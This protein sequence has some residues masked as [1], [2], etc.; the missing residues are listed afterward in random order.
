MESE[1]CA[2]KKACIDQMFVIL[3]FETAFFKKFDWEVDYVGNPVLDAVK[4]HPVD[5]I[6][7]TKRY[8]IRQTIDCAFTGQPEAGTEN[9]YSTADRG[10]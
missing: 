8:F 3:P 1:P 2:Q 7:T 10:G 4:S 9:D 6:F 5:R